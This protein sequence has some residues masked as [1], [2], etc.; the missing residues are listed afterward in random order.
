MIANL[1]VS[2]ARHAALQSSAVPLPRLPQ[3]LPH[4]P[5]FPGIFKGP[6]LH[7]APGLP[8]QVFS[9]MVGASVSEVIFTL[10]VFFCIRAV[11][12]V[13]H[14]PPEPAWHTGSSAATATVRSRNV[15]LWRDIA[16]K[17]SK[18]RILV[19]EVDE[20]LE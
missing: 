20:K 10:C 17:N 16:A 9:T 19:L 1:H 2:S 8:G 5:F 3:W 14:V 15:R 7:R 18:Q 4:T 12:L 6:P 13:A 11:P